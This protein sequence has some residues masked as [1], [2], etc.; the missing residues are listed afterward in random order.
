[1]ESATTRSNCVTKIS[2]TSKLVLVAAL[3]GDGSFYIFHIT[4]NCARYYVPTVFTKPLLPPR[5]AASRRCKQS[6]GLQASPRIMLDGKSRSRPETQQ[7]C[8]T[9]VTEGTKTQGGGR[10]QGGR[11][12]CPHQPTLYPIRAGYR[13]AA[14]LKDSVVGRGPQRGQ[15]DNR[16][17][18]P[19]P[20]RSIGIV[21]WKN[22]DRYRG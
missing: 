22:A 17:A 16:V 11:R 18:G 20:Q 1:M 15:V 5:G 10:S 8:R 14:A 9:L 4:R 3:P 13:L 6:Q 19:E 21:L 2:G 7:I 12:H